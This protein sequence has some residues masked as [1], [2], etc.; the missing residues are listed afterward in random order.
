M[1][2]PAPTDPPQADATRPARRRPRPQAHEWV[3]VALGLALVWRYAWIM[4]DGFV[5]ARYADNAVL[6]RFGLVYN[7]GEYVEGYSSPLW[8]LWHLP[9][10]AIGLSFWTIWLGTGLLCFAWSGWLLTRVDHQLA[11]A[12]APARVNLPLAFLAGCYGVTSFYTSGLES[13]LVLLVAIAYALLLV[14]P[15]DRAAQALVGLSP[16]VRPELA[17]PFAL[18]LALVAGARW[19]ASACSG[20]GAPVSLHPRHIFGLIELQRVRR[21]HLLCGRRNPQLRHRVGATLRIHEIHCVADDVAEILHAQR[22]M[23]LPIDA[24]IFLAIHAGTS[25]E[26]IDH[27]VLDGRQRRRRHRSGPLLRSGGSRTGDSHTQ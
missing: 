8:M 14:D 23:Q 27:L 10:R 18:A 12:G 25:C 22:R 1:Q 15:R 17:L 4:D 19:R 24:L 7:L 13:P 26:Q 9:L 3:C 20:P 21:V 6:T 11:P 5:Y 16:L 2:H